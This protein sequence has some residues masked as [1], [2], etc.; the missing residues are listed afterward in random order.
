MILHFNTLLIKLHTLK[1]LSKETVKKIIWTTGL[2]TPDNQIRKIQKIWTPI[3][4]PFF[5]NFY[6]PFSSCFY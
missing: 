3:K 4:W 5:R 2:K 6:A 1:A